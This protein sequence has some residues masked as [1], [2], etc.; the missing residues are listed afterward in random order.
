[1]QATAAG[2][3]PHC[4]NALFRITGACLSTNLRRY[5]GVLSCGKS[6]AS[7]GKRQA[8]DLDQ[9]K[10]SAAVP[11]SSRRRS[12]SRNDRLFEWKMSR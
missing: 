8:F 6:C 9:G 11:L 12:F 1:V 7:G 3:N 10:L 4:Y 2:N 5:I